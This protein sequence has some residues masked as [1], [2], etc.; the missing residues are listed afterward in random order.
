[1]LHSLKQ[2]NVQ[3]SVIMQCF[4]AA[5]PSSPETGGE[6][7]HNQPHSH[8]FGRRTLC[9]H[10]SQLAGCHAPC[11]L[12]AVHQ[13]SPGEPP[14]R[15]VQVHR[16]SWWIIP[17]SDSW[18][19]DTQLSGFSFPGHSHTFSKVQENSDIYWMFQRY[20][21]IVEYHS[22]PC[23]APPFIILSHLNLLIKRHIRRIPSAKSQHFGEQRYQ[24]STTH[25]CCHGFPCLLLLLSVLSS[26]AEGQEG[27]PPPHMGGRPQRNPAL[28]S[29]QAAEGDGHGTAQTY[30]CQVRWFFC[31]CYNTKRVFIKL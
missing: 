16:R 9:E 8:R 2:L 23:L 21:L 14:H 18:S 17:V 20:N 25:R 19:A 11:R 12:P 15:Y 1:M 30:I 26:G 7:V 27:Q 28:S 4:P 24:T 13:H 10:R 3:Y 31:C 29:E 6:A 22:R 5:P